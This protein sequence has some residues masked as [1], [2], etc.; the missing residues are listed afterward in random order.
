MDDGECDDSFDTELAN[1]EFPPDVPKIP[2]ISPAKPAQSK[3]ADPTP[4]VVAAAKQT[5]ANPHCILVNPKQRGNP[6]LKS[7]HNAPIEFREIV[8]DYI[9]G[10]T[11]CILYLSLK[12]HNLNPD[13]I[14]QRLKNLGKQF[15]LRVLLVQVDMPEPYDALKNLT[16]VSLL[17]DLTLMLA[18]NAEEAGKIIETYKLFEKRPPDLIMER[19][20]SNPHQKLVSALTNIKPVN[21]TDAVTLL[22]NFGSLEKI[23][24]ST[25]DRLSLCTGLGPRKAKKLHKTLQEPFMASK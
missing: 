11:T 14:C 13:Y 5:P 9:V 7:I 17:A 8:P 21:K 1:I 23:I 19:V 25:E 4:E 22:Q 3:V 15:E 20:D 12:Y 6:I 16:R 10:R 24:N 2:K 18:W